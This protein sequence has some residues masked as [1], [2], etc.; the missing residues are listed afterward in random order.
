M[1]AVPHSAHMELPTRY[2]HVGHAR[3]R[4]TV[5]TLPLGRQR[6]SE[7]QRSAEETPQG[8]GEG[9]V[10]ACSLKRLPH[11]RPLSTRARL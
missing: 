10:I 5:I 9:A 7:S 11:P 8:R 3:A 6:C 1:V 4:G 2:A